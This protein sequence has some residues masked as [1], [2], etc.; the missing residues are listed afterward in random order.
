MPA[1]RRIPASFEIDHFTSVLTGKWSS[2]VEGDTSP[3]QK[4]AQ[5]M[6]QNSTIMTQGVECPN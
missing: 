6:T 1:Q 4:I 5:I 3:R 2:E